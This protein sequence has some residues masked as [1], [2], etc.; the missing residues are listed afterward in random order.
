MNTIFKEFK[1]RWDYNI[2]Q[3]TW[4]PD[5]DK[6][7]HPSWSDYG[8]AVRYS[9]KDTIAATLG[10]LL[11]HVFTRQQK[12]V[13]VPFDPT[14]WRQ[15]RTKASNWFQLIITD[16][17]G[18]EGLVYIGKRKWRTWDN[19]IFAYMVLCME[20]AIQARPYEMDPIS[21]ED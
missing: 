2:C 6:I 11:L 13:N 3:M 10:R 15:Y 1:E 17:W 16:V 19:R 7:I 21:W 18:V 14:E 9:T 4:D 20:T 5:P 12:T 8:K